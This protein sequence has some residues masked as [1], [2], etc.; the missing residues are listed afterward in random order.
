[1]KGRFSVILAVVAVNIAGIML[2]YFNLDTYIILA[3]F[4]FQL[5]FVL[6]IIVLA[7]GL[8]KGFIKR[9]FT[10]PG[11]RH[12]VLPLAWIV[13]PVLIIGLLLFLFKKVSP[14]D[15]EYFYEFGLSSVIDYPVYLLWNFPQA[16][17]LFIFLDLAL[18]KLDGSILMTVIAAA[19]IFAYEFVPLNSSFIGYPAVISLILFAVIFVLFIKYYGNIYWFAILVF[20]IPWIYFLLF[21]STAGEIVHLLF[22]AR[23]TSWEGF[24]DCDKNILPFVLAAQLMLTVL[25]M[26]LSLKSR[27]VNEPRD[28]RR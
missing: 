27:G 4:R 18:R 1:M 10:S 19:S 2:R 9:L 8:E 16:M 23:Y 12:S 28:F 14:G 7:G 13:V 17:L 3:G 22:A 24:L 21:G 5:S 6:P 25:V 26:A 15:P 20:S 11:R